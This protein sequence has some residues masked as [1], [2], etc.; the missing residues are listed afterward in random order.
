MRA[1]RVK[2]V[3]RLRRFRYIAEDIWGVFNQL[4][5]KSLLLN[6]EGESYGKSSIDNYS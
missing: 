1:L 2:I 3:K 4:M 6:K 5:G